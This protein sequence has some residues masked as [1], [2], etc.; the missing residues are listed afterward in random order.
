MINYSLKFNSKHQKIHF[1]S[2]LHYDHNRDFI[3]G[4]KGRNYK[5]VTEMNNDII[6]QWNT[7]IG[8]N[9]IAFHLGDIIF[10]D[11]DGTKLLNLYDRLNFKRLYCLFGNHTSGERTI[12][13][14][15]MGDI[16]LNDQECYPQ[17]LDLNSEKSVV[18]LGNYAEIKIDHQFIVLC[19]YPL[20]SWNKQ[21]SGSWMIN[22]HTHNNIPDTH[23]KRIDV[24]WDFKKRPVDFKEMCSLMKNR[25]GHAGDFTQRKS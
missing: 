17:Q 7:F 13:K 1:I 21:A 23:M 11:P 15:L 4:A 10:G 20:A 12:M 18:Y 5:N 2:D 24:G 6:K 3:W 9:D 22:G 8:I 25:G 14:T 19:H 16:G